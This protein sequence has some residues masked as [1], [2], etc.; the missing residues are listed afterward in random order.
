M[1]SSN[2]TVDM[3]ASIEQHN[4]PTFFQKHKFTIISLVILIVALIPLIIL[5]QSSKKSQQSIQPIVTTEAPT[6]APLT[7]E[8]AQPTINAMDQNIQSAL[9][10]SQTE[11]NTANQV[12]ITQDSTTGL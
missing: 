1:E 10:D 7:T 3:P 12:D 8:N 2:A 9:D 6:S 11:L 4:A 5:T